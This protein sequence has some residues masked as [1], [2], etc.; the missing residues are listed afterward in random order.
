[1][2]VQR[3]IILSQSIQR[4]RMKKIK[5]WLKKFFFPS[6]NAP[7]WQVILPYAVLGLL[8]LT[9]I[10]AGTYGWNYTNSPNFCADGCHT[11]PPQGATYAVSPHANILCTECHIGRAF[12]G[13]QLS[14]K[15]Q[16]V[17]ELYAMVT[18]SYEFPIRAKH[19]FPA[20]ET[21]EQCHLPEKFSDDY[22]EPHC[23]DH[24]S[25][26]LRWKNRSSD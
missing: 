16:D 14:R 13:T 21:C 8:T 18:A 6:D 5:T 24:K 25:T 26:K 19:L 20:R 1:M 15:V 2:Q 10:V 22:S 17:R 23:Q 12:V 7:R 9:V 3:L 4:K 11:M